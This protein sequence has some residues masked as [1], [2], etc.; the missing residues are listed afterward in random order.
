VYVPGR[1][2]VVAERFVHVYEL[3]DVLAQFVPVF[4]A[5][6]LSEKVFIEDLPDAV[7][8]ENKLHV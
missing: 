7:P 6:L 5:H 4:V 3:A 2:E 8:F 1:N